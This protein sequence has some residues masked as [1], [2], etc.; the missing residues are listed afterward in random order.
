MSARLRRP[1]FLIGVPL[2]LLL[3]GVAALVPAVRNVRQAAARSADL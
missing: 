1:L 3:A 2:G